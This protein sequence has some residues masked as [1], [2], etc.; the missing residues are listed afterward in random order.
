[1][2]P[3]AA[4]TAHLY[5]RI[6]LE[7]LLCREPRYKLAADL[8]ESRKSR[9]AAPTHGRAWAAIALFSDSSLPTRINKERNDTSDNRDN[10]F[11]T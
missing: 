6:I 9:T 11:G 2:L 5:M 7:K 8:I 10:Y 4:P 1:M 3:V